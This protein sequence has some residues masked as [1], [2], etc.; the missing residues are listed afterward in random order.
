[1]ECEVE[2][3]V[4]VLIHELLGSGLAPWFR[5]VLLDGDGDTDGAIVPRR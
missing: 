4:T 1:M 5:D 3:H 2:G